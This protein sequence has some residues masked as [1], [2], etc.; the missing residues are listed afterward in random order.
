PRTGAFADD[1]GNELGRRLFLAADLKTDDHGDGARVVIAPRA[2]RP[3]ALAG[4]EVFLPVPVDVDVM[5]GVRLRHDVA[6][7]MVLVFRF[8]VG[9]D[10]FDPPDARVMGRAHHD[11]VVAVEVE[12]IDIDVRGSEGPSL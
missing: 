8:G 11:V 7:E 1:V 6:D 5:Q 3:P 9:A 10:V 4:D 2:V 12:I